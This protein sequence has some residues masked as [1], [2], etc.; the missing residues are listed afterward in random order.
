MMHSVS[1][2]VWSRRGKN[3]IYNKPLFSQ[4]CFTFCLFVCSRALI[5]GGAAPEIEVALRLMETSQSLSGMEA[6][7]VRAFAEA[8]EVI[9]FTLAENAGLQPIAV[10]TELRKRHANGEKTAG[11]NVRK[12]CWWA[13]FGYYS[14]CVLILVYSTARV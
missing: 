6:Y 8:M 10:V 9:P 1:S 11:I 12:V 14:L 2:D 3:L 4:H 7:C 5:A 13:L